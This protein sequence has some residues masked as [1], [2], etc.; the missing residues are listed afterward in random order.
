MLIYTVDILFKLQLKIQED[1]SWM[2]MHLILK[3]LQV[4]YIF[5]KPWSLSTASKGQETSV[6]I[7]VLIAPETVLNTVDIQ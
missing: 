3:Q 2:W 6:I 1:L 4:F 5:L 7:T